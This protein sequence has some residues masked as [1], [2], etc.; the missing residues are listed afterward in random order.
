VSIRGLPRSVALVGI[1]GS[2]KTTQAHRLVATLAAAGVPARY[3]QNA[4]GRHWIGRQV[5]RF[6]LR[7]AEQVLGRRGMLLVES[8]LRW[9]AI[10][11]SRLTARLHRDV[12]V[13]DRYAVC[14][15]ASIRAHGGARGGRSERLARL[16][17]GLFRPPGLTVYLAVSP[18][19]A[20]RRVEARGIDQESLEHLVAADAAYR[21]LPEFAGL[22]VVDG[23]GTPDQV[24]AGILRALGVALSVK[25]GVPADLPAAGS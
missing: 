16:A 25:Q 20:H 2:G 19:E 1:D 13:M 9:L 5:Q 10:A 3:V 14:Q 15:Y 12:L 21:S 18:R 17:Y 24:A 11:R 7:D 22:V 8:V 6:G 4:G 23:D